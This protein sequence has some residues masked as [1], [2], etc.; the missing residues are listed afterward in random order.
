MTDLAEKKRINEFR[1][2]QRQYIMTSRFNNETFEENT[3][4]RE[5][6]KNIGC[7]YC[8]PDEIS[9]KIPLESIMFVLEMNNDINKIMGIGMIRNKSYIQKYKVYRNGNYNRYVYIGKQRI[10]RGDMTE[11]EEKIMQVFDIL[12]FKGNRHMKR[13]QG[14]KSFPAEMLYRCQQRLDLTDFIK[15]M[16]KKR[17]ANKNEHKDIS[18]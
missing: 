11:E 18:I 5:N 16:F 13:G 1:K 17:M 9:L 3:K 7:I 6:N 8:S 15:K 10:D 4:Y 14:I 2:E 12:C